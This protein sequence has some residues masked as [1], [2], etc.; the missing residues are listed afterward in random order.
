MFPT[1]RGANSVFFRHV[2]VCLD[3]DVIVTPQLMSHWA[4]YERIFEQAA[5]KDR[6]RTAQ[7]NDLLA[8]VSPFARL[9]NSLTDLSLLDLAAAIPDSRRHFR[10]RAGESSSP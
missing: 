10:Y 4:Q 9:T 3:S 7:L 2:V 8:A 1:L 6:S 5:E